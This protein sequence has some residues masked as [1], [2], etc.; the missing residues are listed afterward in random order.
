MSLKEKI[1]KYTEHCLDCKVKPCSNKGCPLSNDIPTFIKYVK[2]G[3]I[4]KT[5][6][7]NRAFFLFLSR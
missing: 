2:E 4:K 6:F 3:N 5:W 7:F 1:N